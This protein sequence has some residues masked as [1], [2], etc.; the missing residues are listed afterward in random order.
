[1][2]IAAGQLKS[3]DVRVPEGRCLDVAAAIGDG[4]TGVDLRLVDGATGTEIDLARA[5]FATI[6]HACSEGSARPIRIE[7]RTSTGAADAIVA[8]RIAR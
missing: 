1:V 2:R 5:A 7:L 8:T 6:A 3:I 4:A